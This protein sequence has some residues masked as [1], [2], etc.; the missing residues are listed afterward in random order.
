MESKL[1]TLEADLFAAK[2][3]IKNLS[4]ISF[5]T[6][7]KKELETLWQSVIAFWQNLMAK[8]QD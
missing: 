1:K 3:E 4:E 6:Q 7:L 8:K 5:V 2:E